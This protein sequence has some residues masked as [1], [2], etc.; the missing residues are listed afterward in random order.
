MYLAP[1]L[2]IMNSEEFQNLTEHVVVKDVPV[3][4]EDTDVIIDNGYFENRHSFFSFC[5]GNHYQFDTLRH[6][7]HSSMMI[8]Y[9]LHNPTKQSVGTSCCICHQDIVVNQGWHCEI[10]PR[11]D[12]CD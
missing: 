10:C 7:K 11:F 6:V 12:A 4:T 3:N 1:A 2:V 8:L 5:Q 9:Y